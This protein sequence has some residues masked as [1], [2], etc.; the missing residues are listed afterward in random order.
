[1]LDSVL[2]ARDQYLSPDGL[3]IPSHCTLRIAP[4]ADPDYIDDH[5]NFWDNVYGFDMVSMQQDMY[6]DALIRDVQSS[7]LPADSASFRRLSMY[8]ISKDELNF[9]ESPFEF[10]LKSDVEAL[11]AFIIWFD[12]FFTRSRYDEVAQD[13]KAETI[14]RQG[15]DL[16]AFTTG[17]YGPRTHWQQAVLLV[18][19]SG[20][21]PEALQTGQTLSGHIG[22][23]KRQEDSR[24]LNIE[25]SW[26]VDD[27]NKSNK[28]NWSM[29]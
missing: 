10:V 3:M 7:T 27:R 12:T 6:N 21:M 24:A 11:D 29:R 9:K 26:H 2:W 14:L 5:I 15:G 25:V 13:A 19:H 28:Q 20:K 17:P 23:T 1:M 18:N 4:M 8:D 16:I 22:Y